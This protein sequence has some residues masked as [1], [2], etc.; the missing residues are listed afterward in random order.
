MLPFLKKSKTTPAKNTN[1]LTAFLS[2]RVIPIEEVKDPVFS[3]KMLGNG[4]AIEPSGSHCTI[5]APC[6]GVISTVMEDS[7]HAVGLTTPN[8]MELLIHEGIDT[9]SLKGEGFTLHVKEGD[10]VKTGDKLIGFDGAL[11]ASKG[12]QTTCVLA[13]TNSDEY[14]EVKFYTGMEAVAGETVIAEV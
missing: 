9:V 10:R 4:L 2:G 7:K 3:T 8:D 14:P 13:V 6:D 5:L 11:I 1:Q 12:Y